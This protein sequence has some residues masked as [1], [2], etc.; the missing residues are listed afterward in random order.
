MLTQERLKEILHYDSETGI[1]V[2][3]VTRNGNAL[4]GRT[5]GNKGKK[6]YRK[7][8]I[9]KRTYQEHRLAWLYVYGKWPKGVI[10]HINVVVDENRI[11]N[12][13]DTTD[14]INSQNKKSARIDNALGILGVYKVGKRFRAQISVIGRKKYLGTFETP[15]LAS[16]AYLDAKRKLHQGCTI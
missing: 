5:A 3:R 16:A 9:D 13:R 6:G 7:I 1:F 11:D 12:L 4:A 2:W 15:E 8:A 14:L 10:D